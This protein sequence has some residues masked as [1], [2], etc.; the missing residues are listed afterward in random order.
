MVNF[1]SY[2]KYYT[3]ID[4]R[5]EDLRIYYPEKMILKGNRHFLVDNI[6]AET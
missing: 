5:E 6:G 3:I 4:F 1:C 2:P